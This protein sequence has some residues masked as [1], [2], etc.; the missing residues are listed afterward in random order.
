[1]R[2]QTLALAAALALAACATTVRDD[3]P[4]EPTWRSRDA[5]AEPLPAAAEAAADAAP[6]G[7]DGEPLAAYVASFG[8][9]ERVAERWPELLEARAGLGVSQRI[10]DALYDSGAFRFLEE[11]AEMAERIADFRARAGGAAEAPE[12]ARWLLYGELVDVQVARDERVAGLAGR[13]EETT[14]ATVQIRL[15]DRDGG[16]YRPATATGAATRPAPPPG[17]RRGVGEPEALDAGALAEA[18]GEAVRKAAAEL[19]ARL[20]AE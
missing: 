9:S 18:T 19:L 1:M 3:A 16:G 10:A 14:R 6:G 2:A 12:A 11:K 17:R 4:A 13:A 20:E 5:P 15:V 7:V 8:L